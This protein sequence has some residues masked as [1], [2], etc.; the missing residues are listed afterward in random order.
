MARV[1]TETWIKNLK[2]A[3]KRQDFTE[4]GR[5]GFM[6]R[7]WPGGEKTFVVRYQIDGKPRVMTL[8]QWP[9]TSLEE[10]HE[11][12]GAARKALSRG[13]DPM[14]AHIAERELA[15]RERASG[16]ITVRN[17]VA[18]WAW[19]YARKNRKRPREAV[20]LLTT[21]LGGPWKGRPARELRRR[22]GVLLLDRIVAR[23]APV[24]ANRIRDLGNQVFTFAVSRDLV[25]INP[26]TG[27]PR[28]GGEEQSA[29]RWLT[30]DE[31]KAFWSAM[32]APDTAISNQV[33]LGLKLLLVTAQRP[34]EVAQARFDQFDVEQCVWTIPAAIAKNGREHEVPLT[35]LALELLEALRS[36]AKDRPHLLPS[37]QSKLKPHEPISERAMSRALRNNVSD[38]KKPLLFGVEPFTPHDL[39][40]TAAT[41]M[42][43]LGTARLHV[44]KVL[45]HTDR[46]T[47][48]I[49]D[50]HAYLDE[51]RQA[52]QVWADELQVLVA[53]KKRKVVPIKAA[54]RDA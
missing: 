2:P 50:R 3:A 47:T 29:E 9:G 40:R 46:E 17:V 44:S 35:D 53:G 5:K 26:F 13:A 45:N 49:Y 8:G 54:A 4:T 20:R 32:D 27:V 42:T 15:K 12:H 36:I 14:T 41:H 23:G 19:H 24:M 33:R 18:E 39:R 25:D 11:Q 16:A 37:Q 51:K 30:A 6:L 34:G 1:F 31:L 52:L 28:P 21:Y 7:L 10:A 43:M 38:G 22:D 48:A